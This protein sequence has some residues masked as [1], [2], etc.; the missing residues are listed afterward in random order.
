MLSKCLNICSS[1]TLTLADKSENVPCHVS[2]QVPNGFTEMSRASISE[3]DVKI[4]GG[5]SSNC[6]EIVGDGD[7]EFKRRCL[8]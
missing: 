2:P 7:P 3:N 6:D 8:L 4:G 5:Q 1:W